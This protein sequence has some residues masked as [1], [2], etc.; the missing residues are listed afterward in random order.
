M[1]SIPCFRRLAAPILSAKRAS[2]ESDRIAKIIARSDAER[3]AKRDT[4]PLHL[5]HR[6]QLNARH[7]SWRLA[8]SVLVAVA[9][10]TVCAVSAYGAVLRSRIPPVSVT[11]TDAP[12]SV[13]MA[14]LRRRYHIEVK[15]CDTGYNQDRITMTVADV[16]IDSVTNI[17]DQQTLRWAHWKVPYTGGPYTLLLQPQPDLER[18]WWYNLHLFARSLTYLGCHR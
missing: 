15:A 11:F 18:G 1:N 14:E 17:I 10:C 7:P 16:P 2:G 12:L 13:V 5:K 8:A 3:A 4:Q 9:I 6:N